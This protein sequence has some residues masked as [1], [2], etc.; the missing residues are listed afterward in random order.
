MRIYAS[1]S[2]TA[3]AAVNISETIEK[4]GLMIFV[5]IGNACAIMVGNNIGAKRNDLAFDYSRKFLFIAIFGAILIG[6][7][8]ILIKDTILGLYN[9]DTD[10]KHTVSMLLLMMSG[11]M[12]MKSANI[13]FNGGILR[14]GGDTRFSM[15]LDI[16]GVWLIG[17][18]MGAL[19]AYYFHLPVYFVV[20]FVYTEELAKMS[21][22]FYRFLSN[23]WLRNL[24]HQ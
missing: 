8:V 19:A 4:M 1:I 21:L 7:I 10:G 24:V 22:G 15:M 2:T 6:G 13:I 16:G 11:V 20:L 3:I 12:W 18:P 23:K 9:L 5:G 14:G 17:A